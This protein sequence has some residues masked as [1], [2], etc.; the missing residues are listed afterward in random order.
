ML[1]LGYH[2]HEQ[3]VGCEPE[4]VSELFQ[5]DGKSDDGKILGH[6]PGQIDEGEIGQVHHEHHGPEPEP[7]AFSGDHVSAEDSPEHE[8]EHAH[9][10]VNDADLRRGQ[11][12]AAGRSRIQQKGGDHLHEL[13][14][15]KSVKEK[16]SDDCDDFLF[17]EEE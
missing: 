2:D 16:K 15:G 1:P 6:G 7:Q 9:R 17:P 3:R 10:P 13:G 8:H 11:A 12:E 14:L 5:G 4:S